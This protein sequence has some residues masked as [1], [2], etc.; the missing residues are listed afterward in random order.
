MVWCGVL[1]HLLTIRTLSLKLLMTHTHFSKISLYSGYITENMHCK[2]T[3][4]S[5]HL[6]L[7]PVTLDSTIFT[8]HLVY[9]ATAESEEEQ[10]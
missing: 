10:N 4:S 5:S 6:L 7:L 8:L 1:T 3:I 2:L 9:K